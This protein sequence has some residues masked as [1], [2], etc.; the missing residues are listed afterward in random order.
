VRDFNGTELAASTVT[1]PV[2]A[3]GTAE[4]TFTLTV[5]AQGIALA[6]V[7]AS[8]GTDAAFAR[9]TLAALPPRTL[10]PSAASMFG[11]AN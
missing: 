7:T 2:G 6:E 10:D 4:H 3:A 11:M 9:T 5:P 1:V 8:A